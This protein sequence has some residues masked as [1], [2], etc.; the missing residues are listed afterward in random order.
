MTGKAG[1]FTLRRPQRPDRRRRRDAHGRRRELHRAPRQARH[2]PPQQHRRRCSRTAPRRPGVLGTNEGYGVDA[3]LRLLPERADRRLPGE[4][5]DGGPRRRR[6]QLSRALRLQRRSL[7]PPGRAAG[8][9]AELPAGDRLRPAHRHAAQLRAGCAS[10]RGPAAFR[11][12]QADD[13]GQAELLTN[14][15]NRLDTREQ[16]GAF[17][18]EFTNSDVA[19][20]STPTPSSGWCGRSPIVPG[21]GI[22]VGAYD[23]H[24]L[25]LSYTGG[26]QRQV[27]GAHRL[28]DR[29]RST[30][31]SASRSRVNSARVQ[32]TPRISIEPSLT[33]NWVELPQ[34][35]F[36]TRSFAARA[37]FTVT[38]R[39]FV[40]GIVQYN[41]PRDRSAATCGCDG[42]TC[43]AASSSSST[44]TTTIPIR[45]PVPEPSAIERSSSSS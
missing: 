8:R 3:T 28:R 34:G 1:R 12:P 41:S 11:S 36:T 13:A 37:T 5:A 44:P 4:D 25:Q 10:A 31:A 27:S 7:R 6:S 17:Q 15:E 26:Q 20:V 23:F 35:A 45:S 14:T 40:S 18:T 21:V 39:M 22:P 24:T 42:N 19:G 29:A 32:V 43:L 33:L 38:P 30:T 16:I 2:P 9:R